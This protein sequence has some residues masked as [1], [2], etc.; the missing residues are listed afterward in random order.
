MKPKKALKVL[1]TYSSWRQ[2]DHDD[3]PNPRDITKALDHAIKI[4]KVTIEN[5]SYQGTE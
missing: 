4:L 2:G 5:S 3:M 1:E